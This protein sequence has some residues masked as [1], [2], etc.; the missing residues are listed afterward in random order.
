M[1]VRGIPDRKPSGG[2]DGGSGGGGGTKM[3]A[4]ASGEGRIN[5]N[6]LSGPTVPFIN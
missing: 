4:R 3:A 2:G 6:P 5:L 1:E